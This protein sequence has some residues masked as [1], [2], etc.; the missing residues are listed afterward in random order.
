M[1]GMII[2][3][4]GNFASGMSSAMTLIGGKPTQFYAIDFVETDT[5]ETLEAS[6]KTSLEALK[7]CEGVVFCTDLAGG[8]PFKS[9]CIVS[10]KAENVE[11]IAGVNLP[12]CIELNLMRQFES[13]AKI[14][15]D[16]M[17][18]TGKE[19]LLRFEFVAPKAT[20]HDDEDGI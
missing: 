6:M 18:A 9:A 4:H 2:C 15:A 12:L 10:V 20:N 1:I 7:E 11:V 17:V 8:T 5:S 16:N 19:Q 14:L 13:D 3:G